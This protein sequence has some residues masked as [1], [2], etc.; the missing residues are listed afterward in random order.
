MELAQHFDRART[1]VLRHRD[2]LTM[3]QKIAFA[4]GMA[5]ITGILAQI[6]VYLPF[7]PIPLTLQTFAVLLSGII[8]GRWWGGVS[9]AI[10]AIGGI[11]GIPWFAG[12]AT[13]F[14]A[15]FGYLVGFIMASLAIGYFVDTYAWTRR[16]SGMLL[17]IGVISM[18]LIYV[19]GTIWLGMWLALAGKGV[20]LP[21]LLGMGVA[22]FIIGDII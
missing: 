2:G 18:A 21:A 17:I 20:A 8:L 9:M 7:T 6:K 13:G 14:G 19:P 12:A 22:P 11:F 16:F 4:L 10:Y 5:V 3:A 1:E 15:T